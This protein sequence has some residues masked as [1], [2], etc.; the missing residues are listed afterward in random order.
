MIIDI[1]CYINKLL[2]MN[3]ASSL[4]IFYIVQKIIGFNNYLYK[5]LAK[6]LKTMYNICEIQ[7]RLN[8]GRYSSK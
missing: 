1:N 2:A 6:L 3:F 8:Y 4:F 7:R 5:V